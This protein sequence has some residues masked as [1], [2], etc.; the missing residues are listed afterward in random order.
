MDKTSFWFKRTIESF[1]SSNKSLKNVSNKKRKSRFPRA[2]NLQK[3]VNISPYCNYDKGSP[4]LSLTLF[5]QIFHPAVNYCLHSTK[6]AEEGDD[7]PTPRKKIALA[8]RTG[9]NALNKPEKLVEERKTR[10]SDDDVDLIIDR[11]AGGRPLPE[12]NIS[13]M[14]IP[15]ELTPTPPG[16]F[17]APIADNPST[18]ERLKAMD[19]RQK[20]LAER[21]TKIDSGLRSILFK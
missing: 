8:K 6:R 20:K 16:F 15:S 1:K 4:S 5:S 11:T 2:T 3:R 7:E 10:A 12:K 18:E 21:L 13:S 9:K 14:A 17:K 19:L